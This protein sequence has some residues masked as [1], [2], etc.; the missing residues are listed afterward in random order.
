MSVKKQ[1]KK[2]LQNKKKKKLTTADQGKQIPFQRSLIHSNDKH[3]S[4]SPSKTMF[5][6]DMQI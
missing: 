3:L 2:K 5:C 6:A 1:Q 4:R